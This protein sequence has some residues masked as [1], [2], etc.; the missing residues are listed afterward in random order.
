MF[1]PYIYTDSS[2]LVNVPH[3][4]SVSLLVFTT[5]SLNRFRSCNSDISVETSDNLWKY[6]RSM[7]KSLSKR[8]LTLNL[9]L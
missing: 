4:N 6:V 7:G 3:E 1:Y 5:C 2:R 8:V 9:A